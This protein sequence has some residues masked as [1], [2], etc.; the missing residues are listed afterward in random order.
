MLHP[1]EEHHDPEMDLATTFVL[2]SLVQTHHH[3]KTQFNTMVIIVLKSKPSAHMRIARITDGRTD[4]QTDRQARTHTHTIV[5]LKVHT[6]LRGLGIWIL[7]RVM[8]VVLHVLHDV[9]D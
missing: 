6:W 2:L 3:C 4:R 7:L 5:T 8:L 9:C 1:P